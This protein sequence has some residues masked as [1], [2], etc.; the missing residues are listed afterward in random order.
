MGIVTS[1]GVGKA[2]NWAALT[3]GR[4]G[5]HE[6]TRFPTDHLN[7]R[8]AGTVDFLKSSNGGASRP[9][10]RA[11]RDRRRR[12][13]GGGRPRRHRFRRP[14]VSC[15]AA[16]RARLEA[17]LQ[18]LRLGQSGRR[19]SAPAVGG[20]RPQ[21]AGA[22]RRG[23]VRHDCRVAGRALR[24]PRLADHPVDCLCIRRDRDPAR[25][26]GDPARRVRTRHLDRRRRLGD[27]GSGDPLLA[28]VGAVDPQRAA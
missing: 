8:I 3:S 27:R 1:L 25:R 4:S 7:T 17:A 9:H 11:R 13:D 12:G 2:D 15:V 6:I 19:L 20:A 18:A 22:V 24:G 26:R 16:G 21:H 5:I 28:A 14:A 10:L 23:A